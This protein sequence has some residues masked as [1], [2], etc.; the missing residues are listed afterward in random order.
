LSGANKL[1]KKRRG[2]NKK[3]IIIIVYKDVKNKKTDD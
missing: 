3:I 2:T 1:N